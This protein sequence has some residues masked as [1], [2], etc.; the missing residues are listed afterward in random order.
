MCSPWKDKW[1]NWY[2][3]WR[4]LLETLELMWVSSTILM[5][6]MLSDL[7]QTSKSPHCSMSWI[8]N[9]RRLSVARDKSDSVLVQQPRGQTKTGVCSRL[10]MFHIFKRNTLKH[11]QK[12]GRIVYLRFQSAPHGLLVHVMQTGRHWGT[13]L[14]IRSLVSLLA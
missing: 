2:N 14:N 6:G 12:L 11:F 8:L 3:P 1:A 4:S 7:G 9:S 5:K 13:S 10:T